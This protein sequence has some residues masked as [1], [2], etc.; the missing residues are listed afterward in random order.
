MANV[1]SQ[2]MKSK[3]GTLQETLCELPEVKEDPTDAVLIRMCTASRLG[4]PLTSYRNQERL[5][6]TVAVLAAEDEVAEQST[7]SS[8]KLL[9]KGT[10][11]HLLYLGSQSSKTRNK[12]PLCLPDPNRSRCPRA[13]AATALPCDSTKRPSHRRAS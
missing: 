6:A 13:K 8:P 1:Y 11:R 10:H 9:A 2:R 7:S 3:Q 4:D 5:L 12:L